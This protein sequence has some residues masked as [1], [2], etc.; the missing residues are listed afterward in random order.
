MA[1]AILDGRFERVAKREHS[2][3]KTFWE[4][5]DKLPGEKN[6]YH[7][8]VYGGNSIADYAVAKIKRDSGKVTDKQWNE[9]KD[10]AKKIEEN[11]ELIEQHIDRRIQ[12]FFM[13]LIC[14]YKTPYH[15]EWIEANDEYGKG[16]KLTIKNPNGR[17]T[18]KFGTEAAHSGTF[19]CL[20][21]YPRDEWER[22]DKSNGFVYL[23]Y[24]RSYIDNNATIEFDRYLNR[25]DCLIDGTHKDRQLREEAIKIVNAVG[26]GKSTVEKGVKNFA[27][28][29]E[30]FCIKR[31]AKVAASDPRRL[32]LARYAKRIQD[33]RLV[34]DHDPVYFDQLLGVKVGEHPREAILR[35]IVYQKRFKLIQDCEAIESKIARTIL[36]AQNEILRKNNKS[37]KSVD[38]RLRYVLLEDLNPFFKKTL[39]RLF[40][41]SLEQ[42]QAG[43][44]KNEQRLRNFE[45]SEGITTF[46]EKH[47]ARIDVLK[48]DLRAHFHSVDNLE[49]DYRSELFKGLRWDLNSWLQKN[50]VTEFKKK[51][52]TEPMYPAKISR[53]EQRTRSQWETKAY[54]TPLSQRRKDIDVVL[55]KKIAETFGIDQGLFLPAVVSS[56]Y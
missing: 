9:Q 4:N 35:K 31:Q 7:T 56:M 8:Q 20:V 28:L 16:S 24:G 18:Q 34:M 33:V 26:E 6:N 5:K 37:L 52:P 19:P 45:G 12:L 46:R 50:F 1:A 41:T 13:Q 29:L 32:V 43:I 22:G 36:T 15:F 10:P 51:Y 17:G 44:E 40:C 39:E 3:L 54:V 55:A 2:P 47:R 42:L 49:L 38:S 25:A 11:L 48:R 27:K 14:C 23:K 21:A 30:E 53:M